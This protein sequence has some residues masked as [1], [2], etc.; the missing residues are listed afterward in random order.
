MV[1]NKPYDESVEVSDAEEVTSAQASPRD[2]PTQQVST[3]YMFMYVQYVCMIYV[4][5]FAYMYVCMYLIQN[6]FGVKKGGSKVESYLEVN[7]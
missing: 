2:Q 6:T 3:C 5:M 1:F 4:C 7:T